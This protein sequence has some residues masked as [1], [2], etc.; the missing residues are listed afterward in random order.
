M[1]I[2]TK[3]KIKTGL[4]S[5]SKVDILVDCGVASWDDFTQ[6]GGYDTYS[7]CGNDKDEFVTDFYMLKQASNYFIIKI[8]HD[9]IIIEW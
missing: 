6:L 4:L 2:I 3:V 8:T 1:N 5:S 7:F 9:G